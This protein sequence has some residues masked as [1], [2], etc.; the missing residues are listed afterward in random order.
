MGRLHELYRQQGQSPWLDN[1]KRSWITSGELGRW[2]TRGV[3]GVTSNP[4]I[5]QK[6]IESAE[7]YDEQFHGCLAAGATV[8]E[9]YWDLVTTDIAGALAVLR[10]VYDESD[11]VDG[12]VS[13]E[14]APALAD[15]AAA[16][17]SAARALHA[18]L[19]APNL[20]VKVP[21]TTAGVDA[22]RQ[23]VADG[24]SVN[25]TLLFSVER[26]EQVI[27]AYLDGL[28][29]NAGDLA[30]VSSVASFFIS[31]VDTEIDRRLDKVGTPTADAL[32][33]KAAIANARLAYGRFQERFSG[34]RWE[35]LAARGARPQRP[36]WASTS[37][38]DPSYPDT[39]YVDSLI[40]PGTVNTLPDATLAAFEEHGALDRT[41]DRD[42]DA[43]FATV[44][45]LAAEGVDLTEVTT[46]LESEGVA[47]FVA[48]F[49]DLLASLDR[50]A[51]P[52]R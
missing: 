20:Y 14:V 36:L 1:V 7:D 12:F 3:R 24:H 27:D 48:S 47:A 42:L 29:A 31:R 18:R 17:I 9:A 50:K 28:E 32:R 34:P 41:L 52:G 35:A 37:T 8:E 13:V 10:P 49:D 6:A 23:L 40:G 21:G 19:A 38:K 39:L 22:F 26:Y 15:D 44:D 16:T 45:A 4:T 30:Q 33:G 2:V 25:V 5:F 46:Q 43:A 11:G 51:E